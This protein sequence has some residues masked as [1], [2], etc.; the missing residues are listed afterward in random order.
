MNDDR[1][2]PTSHSNEKKVD[3]QGRR[4]SRSQTDR[5]ATLVGA[6]LLRWR[7][8]LLLILPLR[9]VAWSLLHRPLLVRRQHSSSSFDGSTYPSFPLVRLASTPFEADF[10]DGNT[11]D[12]DASRSP[13][14]VSPDTRLV[15]GINKYTHDTALCAANA[16]TGQVLFA[17][18]K[19]RLTRRKH[20]AG[21]IAT[22]VDACLEALELDLDNIDKVVLNNHHHRIFPLEANPRHMEWECGLSMNGGAEDGYDEEENLLTSVTDQVELSHHLAHVYSAAAQAPFDHGMVV[23]MDGMGETYRTMSQAAREK[24]S[25]YVSDFSFG[26]D[27]FQ[28][29]PSNLAELAQTSRFDWREAESVYTF[30]KADGRQMDVRPVFK[31][32]TEEHSPPVLCNHGFENMDSAGALYSR[33]S[34]HIFGDWNACGKVMGLAPWMGHVWTQDE[35]TKQADLPD[36]P[37]IKG[38]LYK[39]ADLVIDRSLMEGMPHISRNDADL[40]SADGSQRKRYDFDDNTGADKDD[41]K[42]ARIPSQVALDAIGLAHRMQMDLEDVAMDFVRHFKEVTG[43]TNLCLAGGVALN[44]VLNG[45]LARELGFE[46]SFIPPYPGDDGIA[47]GCCAYGVFGNCVLEKNEEAIE[48]AEDDRPPVWQKPLSPY[49]GAEPS[50]AVMKSALADAEPWLEIETIRDD[51]QRLQIMVDEIAAGGVIAWY[52]SRS[53][54]GP[55]ALGHRSILADPRKKGLVRFINE[56]VKSRESFRP[57]APS[58]LAEEASKWFDLGEHAPTDGNVSP[59]MSMTA[60]VHAEKRDVV[61]AVTHV[62]GSSRM[63]TVTK[64]AEPLYHKLISMFFEKTKVP[65]VLNT[66]FNTLPSEPIVETPAEAI[67]SF[68]YSMGSLEMLVMGDYVIRR[69]APDLRRLLGEASKDGDIRSE[70]ASP[71]RAGRAYFESSL[72][73]DEGPTEEESAETT[74]RVRMPDRPLHMDGKN[75]WFT[76]LDELEGQIL[77]ASDGTVTLNEILAEFTAMDEEDSL[78]DAKVED[79]QVL[80]QNVVHRFVRLYEHTLIYW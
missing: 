61:P 71:R 11:G 32:F 34:S 49:L 2:P 57:F 54:M 51:H 38:T 33:A 53:E 70:P 24:D 66:S 68:L 39:D 37:I 9:T 59:F 13:L 14:A 17:V 26:M 23:V 1:P 74:T 20:D 40:F 3:R 36:T 67:R 12:D 25:Q 42:D 29:V 78:D 31:R 65:M 28:C 7:S 45:R 6:F 55:R 35:A 79:T 48:S 69:K 10:Y 47:V 19:E 58:C 72:V 15:L 52:R 56:Q 63:Q 21:N 77:S 30:T 41:P 22:L 80:L 73:L 43:E 4:I 64:D 5:M 50:E 8:I 16:Q 75:E 62:D 46:Q 44:S 76:L 27:S 18:S 60:L